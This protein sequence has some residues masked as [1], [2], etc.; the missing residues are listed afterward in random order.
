M[1][2]FLEIGEFLKQQ[3]DSRALLL[4]AR[5]PSEYRHAHIPGAVNMPLLDDAQR[6]EVGLTYKQ[7]GR[8][9]AILKGFDLVGPHFSAFARE[10]NNLQD[11]GEV[12][13]YCWR[14]GMR[15]GI[16]SWILALSGY[17]NSLLKGGY[18][19]YRRHVLELLGR[20]RK[21]TVLGGRTGSG[22]TE[23]LQ[24][25]AATVPVIDL[26]GLAR[27]KGSAFGHLGQGQQP[28]NEQFENLLEEKLS[29]FADDAVIWIEN[30]SRN[31]GSVKVP[32]RIYQDI[33]DA[34]TVEMHRDREGRLDRIL[35][36]YGGFDHALLAAATRKVR[37]RLGEVRMNEA[38]DALDNGDLEGWAGILLD[39]YDKSYDYG[40]QQRSP[41]SVVPFAV[42]ANET[43]EETAQ[44][45]LRL[46]PNHHTTSA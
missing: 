16:L 12:Y 11:R 15:S 39:Y 41:G 14:G 45:I 23:V 10:V 22:K 19:S 2:Q 4:D 6:A 42:G 13:I 38:L 43:A 40:M 36:E 21:Y 34:P 18:K 24:A 8:Q 37:K 20:P 33:R 3:R 9:A 1:P 46:A 32:D 17:S 29:V 26:E 25:M 30:E 31:I 28:S 27:H 35:S 5:S 44:R 7:Q